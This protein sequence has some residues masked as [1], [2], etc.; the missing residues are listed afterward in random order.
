[1][2]LGGFS[3]IKVVREICRC[4]AYEY[5]RVARQDMLPLGM[6]NFHFDAHLPLSGLVLASG[7]MSMDSFVPCLPD[8][9]EVGPY[10][11]QSP[12]GPSRASMG[13]SMYL[14]PANV[15]VLFDSPFGREVTI[16]EV[17]P[18]YGGRR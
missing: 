7:V 8:Y 11:R 9:K 15:V 17:A 3:R 12:A 16:K 14:T 1:L 4:V 2:D 5:I 6:K 13:K 10:D 18:S